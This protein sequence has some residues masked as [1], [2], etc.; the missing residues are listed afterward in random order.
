MGRAFPLN[1]TFVDHNNVRHQKK[2]RITE[3]RH[4]QRTPPVSRHRQRPELEGVDGSNVCMRWT[5]ISEPRWPSHRD[6]REK[7]RSKY[8]FGRAGASRLSAF[9]S[10]CFASSSIY[11]RWRLIA[12]TWTSQPLSLHRPLPALPRT[13]FRR[14]HVQHCWCWKTDY[15]WR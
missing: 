8:Y 10:L 2:K 4:R 11:R 3:P 5:G 13:S 1:S 15:S 6:G 14:T 9:G 7:A 12:A